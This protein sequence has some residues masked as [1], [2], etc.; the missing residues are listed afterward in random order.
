MLNFAPE[1]QQ[2]AG[3]PPHWKSLG[4]MKLISKTP[5]DGGKMIHLTFVSV[6]GEGGAHRNLSP[7]AANEFYKDQ[8]YEI[9]A[10]QP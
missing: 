8:V 7:E 2:L 3:P 1:Q 5:V 4:L 10:T 6:D 9:R